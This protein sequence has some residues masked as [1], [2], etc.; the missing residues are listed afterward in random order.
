MNKLYIECPLCRK[1]HILL[2]QAKF[3]R[4]DCTQRSMWIYSNEKLVDTKEDLINCFKNGNWKSIVSFM[5][6]KEDWKRIRP[7]LLAKLKPFMG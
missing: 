7:T 6:N 3:Y 1:D 4:I 5:I 2:T